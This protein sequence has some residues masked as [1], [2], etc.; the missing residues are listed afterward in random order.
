MALQVGR[1]RGLNGSGWEEGRCEGEPPPHYST[2]MAFI[3]RDRSKSL[4]LDLNRQ[5]IES[6]SWTTQFLPAFFAM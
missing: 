3:K 6:Q 1:A 2:R 4:R 5:G